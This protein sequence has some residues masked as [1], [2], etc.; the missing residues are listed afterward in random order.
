MLEGFYYLTHKLIL[1]YNQFKH[2]GQLFT[3]NHQVLLNIQARMQIK[4]FSF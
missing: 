2:R 1:K 3:N 4:S